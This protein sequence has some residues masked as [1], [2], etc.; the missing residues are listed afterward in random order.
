MFDADLFAAFPTVLPLNRPHTLREL[1]E[2][3]KTDWDRNKPLTH[4]LR[5]GGN[6]RKAGNG[7]AEN[8]DLESSFVY[9]AIAA[10]LI[11]ENIPSHP[12]YNTLTLEQRDALL[13]VSPRNS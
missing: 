12:R 11:L 2:I 1:V 6:L 4:W 7:Y 5:L 13:A 3:V 9:L 8:G 10:T